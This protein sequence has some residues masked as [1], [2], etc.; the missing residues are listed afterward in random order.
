[1]LFILGKNAKPVSMVALIYKSLLLYQSEFR[2]PSGMLKIKYLT[3]S[4]KRHANAKKTLT[5]VTLN[6]IQ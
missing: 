3:D 4:V 1:M 2:G 5:H 6:K